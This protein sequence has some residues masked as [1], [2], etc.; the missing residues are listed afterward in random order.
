MR[1]LRAALAVVLLTTSASALA[2]EY[3]H[4]GGGFALNLGW[5]P[6][7]LGF[8]V[9]QHAPCVEVAAPVVMPPPVFYAQ[10]PVYYSPPPPPPVVYVPTPVAPA[11]APPA[12]A[13]PPV[14]VAATPANWHLP[15][16]VERPAF[17]AIKYQPGL[18]S[19]VDWSDHAVALSGP[20]LTHS[21]GLEARLT[22]W[23]ALRSDFEQRRGS[24]S[25]DVLGVKLST[26]GDTLAPYAS[27]SV[28]GSD[29]A[30]A[31]RRYQ[32]GLVGALGLDFKLGRHFFIEAEAR[33]R[34]APDS[35]CRDVPQVTGTLGVGVALF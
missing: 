34:V 7:A 26:T 16:R 12:P 11:P 20:S 4:V 18:T 15:P 1:Q 6:I 24:R 21:F 33:Y 14:A 2:C 10:A 5:L 28:S 29:S 9:H 22:K 27:V 32:L 30:A 8:R 25:W 13:P 17:L 31:P 3:G 23:L 35:C 19:A